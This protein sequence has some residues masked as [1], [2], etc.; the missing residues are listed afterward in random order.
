MAPFSYTKLSV[1]VNLLLYIHY[2]TR[3]GMG[4]GTM[5]ATTVLIVFEKIKVRTHGWLQNWILWY[6]KKKFFFVLSFFERVWLISLQKVLIWPQQ[7]FPNIF[8]M[9]IKIH[10]NWCRF[11]IR[12]KSSSLGR[13][14]FGSEISYNKPPPRLPGLAY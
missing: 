12:W 4:V 2:C 7:F 3:M 5:W 11:R 9:G 1:Y 8:N 14:V 10:I 13:Y 6:I